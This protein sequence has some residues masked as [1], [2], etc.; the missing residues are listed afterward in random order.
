MPGRTVGAA[1]AATELQAKVTRTVGAALAATE[2]QAKATKT[3]GAA[4][5]ATELLVVDLKR[6]KRF[7]ARA[8]QQYLH[9]LLGLF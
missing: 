9:L 6:F 2:L 4:L 5:A 3:V 7:T 1:L 8:L